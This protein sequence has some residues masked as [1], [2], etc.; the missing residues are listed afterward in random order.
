MNPYLVRIL[1][2]AA[3]AAPCVLLHAQEVNPADAMMKRMRETLRSTM[4]QLQTAQAEVA[5]LQAK[6][7]ESDSKIQ[8]LT[9]ELTTLTK[10]ADAD[11]AAAASKATELN[12]Q[13]ATKT[14]E[15]VMLTQSL[16]KWKA[17]YKQAAEVANATEAKRSQLADKVILLDRRVA[18]MQVKNRELYKLGSEILRRYENFGLGTALL[19]REPFT[20]IARVKFETLVQD[21]ADKLTDQ[22][23]KPGEAPADTPDSVPAE[24]PPATNAVQTTAKASP[25]KHKS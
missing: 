8:E 17:G 15:V 25:P 19:A 13:I 20:G 4:I 12:G 16:E 7:V 14:Q 6:Q 21:Y 11:K 1:M 18:D 9:A 23:L 22:K 10:Q 2:T 5:T 24:S 3:L